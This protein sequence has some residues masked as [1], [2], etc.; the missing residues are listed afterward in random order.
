MIQVSGMIGQHLN[1]IKILTVSNAIT[2]SVL[3][4]TL[5]NALFVKKI[6][7]KIVRE[8]VYLVALLLIVNLVIV[9]KDLITQTQHPQLVRVQAQLLEIIQQLKH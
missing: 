9:N 4:K 1:S 3:D 5:T 8:Y 7:M 6:N 2:N